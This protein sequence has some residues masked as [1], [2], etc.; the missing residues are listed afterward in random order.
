MRGHSGDRGNDKADE[1][2]TIGMKNGT[3]LKE[4]RV[5]QSL[6]QAAE[7]EANKRREAADLGLAGEDLPAHQAH[8]K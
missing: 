3:R 2:A 5:A 8:L 1:A 7:T 6:Q 4:A